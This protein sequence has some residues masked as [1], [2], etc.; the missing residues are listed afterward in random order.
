MMYS[1]DHICGRKRGVR[2]HAAA[3][4][5]IATVVLVIVAVALAA[6]HALP[7]LTSF[8]VKS[9]SMEPSLP[10][11]SLIL[12]QQLSAQR[13]RD[14]DVITFHLPGAA[15]PVTH[16]VI[17]RGYR[18]GRWQFRTRGDANSSADRWARAGG[19]QPAGIAGALASGD[20]WI[21]YGDRPAQRVLFDVPYLGSMSLFLATPAMR[22]VLTVLLSLLAAWRVLRLIWRGHPLSTPVSDGRT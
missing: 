7:G 15:R 13:V 10:V 3:P 5:M 16:R 17:E 9:G 14:G 8:V 18:D 2:W 4:S 21:T 19:D 22:T 20:G 6:V 11:G 1:S 12:V